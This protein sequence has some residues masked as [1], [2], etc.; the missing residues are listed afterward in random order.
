MGILQLMSEAHYTRLWEMHLAQ[1]TFSLRHLLQSMIQLLTELVRTGGVFAE[2]W[3]VM[4]MVSNHTILTAMQEIAQPLIA[5]FLKNDRF[6]NQL[7][8]SYLNL[9]VAFL[10][11]PSLQLE[12]FS[13]Q[14]RHKVLERY[15]DMR[16]LMGFQILSMW[17]NLDEQRLHFIPGMVGPFLEVTLVPEPELRKATLPIFFDMMQAEQMAKGNFKQVETELI[18]KL[19]ILVSENKGDD[20]YRQLFNT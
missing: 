3:F 4:R 10:T 11:Q 15:N 5:T 9:A 16:V 2:D 6:D 14:K 12:H 20:E 8:S 17:H 19:D 18:D 13:Q 1:D 7:W